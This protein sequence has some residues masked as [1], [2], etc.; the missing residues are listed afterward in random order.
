MIRSLLLLLLA[1][2][3]LSSRAQAPLALA[4]QVAGQ[5]VSETA[6]A[7]DLIPYEAPLGLQV[8]DLRYTL[9]CTGQGL[10]Y[11]LGSLQLDRP[12]AFE[13]GLASPGALTVWLDGQQ[14]WSGRPAAPVREVAP[15]RLAFPVNLPLELPAGTHHLLL[16]AEAAGD[17][18]EITLRPQRAD[19]VPLAGLTFQAPPLAQGLDAQWLCLGP[20]SP[21]QGPDPTTDLR[22]LYPEA[23]LRWLPAAHPGRAQLQRPDGRWYP[24]EGNADWHY[25]HGL[26]QYA[27]LALA[28][29]TGEDRWRQYVDD[30]LA[31]FQAH[32]AYFAQQYH[33]GH[34]LRPPFFRY[35]RRALPEDLG[36]AGLGLLGRL[37]ED[38]PAPGWAATGTEIGQ[39]LMQGLDRRPD[40]TLCRAEPS[41]GA[42]WIDDLLMSVPAALLL[43]QGTGDAAYRDEATRQV[44]Q[45]GGYLFDPEKGLYYHG[46]L[47]KTRLHNGICWGRGNGIAAWTLAEVL[48]VLPP[49]DPR[50]PELMERFQVLMQNLIRYQS[51]DGAWRQVIDY[52][53]S[54]AETS[55]TALILC[56]LATGVSQGWLPAHNAQAR[57]RAWAWLQTTVDASGR[58]HG[59]CAETEVSERLDDY[60]RRPRYVA[61][62]RGTGP[63]ILAALAMR[64][65]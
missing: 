30:Y 9:G 14:I 63:F 41:P 50:Y 37:A 20:V 11:A 16:A 26:C 46:W 8:I 15:G 38:Q 25:A 39:W 52:P 31:F 61:D 23:G 5:Y 43:A 22:S 64:A 59:T 27:L 1:G 56:A 53:A 65:P 49:R 3:I 44:L 36:G 33:Q 32:Q 48:R 51:E 21:A 19:G 47:P 42:V 13:L 4:R 60:L 55:G 40:G 34:D 58:V 24:G 28:Q 29:A 10:G 18:W 57:D 35:Y 54:Q 45:M 17:R 6:F 12:L 7:F 2:G 62:P